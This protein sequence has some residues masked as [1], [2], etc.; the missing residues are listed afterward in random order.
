MGSGDAQR[1]WF[2]EML[3]ELFTSW[4]AG[5]PVEELVAFCLRMTA[6][7]AQIRGERNILP[8]KMRCPCCGEV[9][10]SETP[11]VSVRS[12]LFSLK[13]HGVI[14]DAELEHHDRAWKRYQRKHDL[15]GYGNKRMP[16]PKKKG[17]KKK[18][19]RC[20]H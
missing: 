8:P 15:D 9:S 1:V 13:K 18:N 6:K 16:E 10:R 5:M 20:L 12:A 17:K 3:E 19:G 2:P 11:G 4:K 7:R 14:T